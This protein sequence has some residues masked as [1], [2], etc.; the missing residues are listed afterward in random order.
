MPPPIPPP[1]RGEASIRYDDRPATT[2]RRC[3]IPDGS[4]QDDELSGTRRQRVWTAAVLTQHTDIPLLGAD[5]R[6]P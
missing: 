2:A 6:R 5:R 3:S 4:F 1:D